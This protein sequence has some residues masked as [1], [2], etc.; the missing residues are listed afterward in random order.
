M[1]NEI[2]DKPGKLYDEE[3]LLHV[4]GDNQSYVSRGGVKLE[5]AL[6]EFNLSVSGKYALDIGAS[7]GGF[8][9][10]LIQNGIKNVY[11][12]ENAH[13]INS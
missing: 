11:L 12:L 9:D 2:A 3:S 4:I 7:T 5:Y 10:C 6:K 8:S 1:D 13:E